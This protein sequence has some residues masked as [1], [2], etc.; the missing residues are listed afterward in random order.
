MIVTIE[1]NSYL[2]V[3]KQSYRTTVKRWGICLS[4]YLPLTDS[5]SIGV[6]ADAN[7][8]DRET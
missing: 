3:T 5:P 4:L 8:D 6:E 7:L 2:I 1:S